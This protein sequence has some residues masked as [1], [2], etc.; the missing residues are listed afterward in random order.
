M[1][2]EDIQSSNQQDVDF[3]DSMHD[4]LGMDKDAVDST[5]EKLDADELQD[6]TDAVARRSAAR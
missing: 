1:A 5:L 4:L 6:L 2:N 3:L